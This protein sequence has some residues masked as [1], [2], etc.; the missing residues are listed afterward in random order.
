MFAVIIRSSCIIS[1]II[2]IVLRQKGAI[3]HKR[4]YSDVRVIKKEF[5]KSYKMEMHLRITQTLNPT[6]PQ[7]H[8]SS[9]IEIFLFAGNKVKEIGFFF[10]LTIVKL[11]KIIDF[12]LFFT[13]TA[14]ITL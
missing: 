13:Q 7:V 14:G 11:S 5:R 4:E 2:V 9:W 10:Y 12:F 3:L 6:G 8:H 1:V